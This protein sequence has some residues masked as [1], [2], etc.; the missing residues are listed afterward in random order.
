MI[1]KSM[2]KLGALIFIQINEGSSPIEVAEALTKKAGVDEVLLISGDWDLVIRLSF[3]EM[4]DLSK[5][6]VSELRSI[7]GVGQTDTKVILDK[8]K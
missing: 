5:F 8:V 1:I 3:E 6:V 2:E 7:K 4:E